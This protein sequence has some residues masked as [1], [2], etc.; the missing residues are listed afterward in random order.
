MASNLHS[1]YWLLCAACGATRPPSEEL[2]SDRP[3]DSGGQAKLRSWWAHA[4]PPAGVSFLYAQE[5]ADQD[6]PGPSITSLLL[7]NYV[8]LGN[9]SAKSQPLCL[10]SRVSCAHQEVIFKNVLSA[11]VQGIPCAVCKWQPEYLLLTLSFG[12]CLLFTFYFKNTQE[13]QIK[14]HAQYPEWTVINFRSYCL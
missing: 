1:I 8:S 2:E 14:L 6:T 7:A 4:H 9:T 13:V 12:L 10:S 11:Q 5:L 3:N